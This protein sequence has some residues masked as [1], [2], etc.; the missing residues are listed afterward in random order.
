MSGESK[1][2]PNGSTELEVPFGAGSYS[3]RDVLRRGALAS[4]SLGG[5][6]LLGPS[7][8]SAREYAPAGTGG[9]IRLGIESSTNIIEPFS[10]NTDGALICA[11]Q[12]LEPLVWANADLIPRPLLAT[13]FAPVNNDLSH[14]RFTL[15]QGVK[16]NNGAS[17]TSAD[18]VSWMDTLLAT[19]SVSNA[20]TLTGS[21][22][23]KGNTK[24]VDPYTVDFMLERAVAQFPL[25]VSNYVPETGIPP[26]TYK[27]G[28]FAKSP[29]GTGPFMLKQFVP[30][31]GSTLVRNPNYWQTGLPHLDGVSI[32]DLSLPAQVIAM[33]AGDLDLMP[34]APLVA[35]GVLR[36]NS[37]FAFTFAESAAYRE[38]SMRVDK[39]PFTDPR[40]REAV[41]LCIDRPSLIT[42]LLDGEGQLGNDHI[43]APIYG[44]N[45]KLPQRK[46]DYQ[47]A[48]QLLEAAGYANGFTVQ[49]TAQDDE[50][51]PEYIA[52]VQQQVGAIGITL[53][54]QIEEAAQFYGTSG[55]PAPWLDN[56]M[57]CSPWNSR[58][59][60]GLQVWFQGGNAFNA[61]HWNNPQFTKLQ[62][63]LEGT[64]EAAAA[65]TL[66]QEMATIMYND[67]PAIIAYWVDLPRVRSVKVHGLPLTSTVHV[68]L[69][70]VTL[71]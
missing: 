44:Y 42:G 8:A 10:L 15:R 22:L 21:V 11:Q 60:Q 46:Q 45:V 56:I 37:K 43:L 39:K 28:T 4:A 47:K 54:L 49:L 18:V 31:T 6:S 9:T 16:Y 68:D 26:Q 19:G 50:E 59:T 1:R 38:L 69:R 25:F 65:H 52:I 53:E 24:A 63:Q 2:P 67:V 32:R 41:A 33:E 62:L 66:A 48:R 3:R 7:A 58:A 40:V 35:S 23:T 61:P 34:Q 64:L 70:R 36:N 51:I 20:A 14:W 27:V 30:Y 55:K 13:S 29:V 12:V 71:S 57:V 17:F 5:L